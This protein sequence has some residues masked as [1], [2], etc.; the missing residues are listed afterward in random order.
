MIR[1]SVCIG[2]A[3]KWMPLLLLLTTAGVSL[4]G[5]SDT[6]SGVVNKY[7]PVL[8]LQERRTGSNVNA[9]K[10]QNPDYFEVGN[11]VML[12]APKGWD[13]DPADGDAV[14]DGSKPHPNTGVYSI[15]KVD[16]VIMADSIIVFV[17]TTPFRDSLQTGE[18]AQLIYV[19]DFRNVVVEGT[20][21]G[22]HWTQESGA[23][24]VIALYVEGRLKLQADIDATGMG[25]QGADPTGDNYT[26]GCYEDDP[27]LYGRG[28]YTAA[29]D[30]LAG[31]KGEG[32]AVTTFDML[33]GKY[34]MFN[35]GGGGN[36]RFSG[37]G[38]GS[39]Y[40]QGGRGG[41]QSAGTCLT[42]SE[43]R[44]RAGI[45]LSGTYYSNTLVS[46]RLYFGGG[47]GTGTQTP[48]EQAS[49]GGDGGGIVVIIADTI[50]STGDYTI[51]SNGES[52]E[53]TALAGG[54]GGGG[55]GA[56]VLDVN[57]YKGEVVLEARGGNGGDTDNTYYTG[58]GGGGGGGIYWLS[59][60]NDTASL[61]PLKTS[62][63]G[64]EWLNGVG[65]KGSP[66]ASAEEYFDLVPPL[67]GFLFNTLPA[68]RTVCTDETPDTLFAS[69]PKGGDGTYTYQ[70]QFRYPPATEWDSLAVDTFQYYVFKGPLTE[71]IQLRRIV[72]SDDLE[73]GRDVFITYS[74]TPKIEGNT[75][76]APDIICAG[77]TAEPLV[78]FPDSILRGADMAL[79]SA[80]TSFKWIRQ[81]NGE[82]SWSDVP[83]AFGAEHTP[84]GDIVTTLY[85]R[86]AYS[87][88]CDDTSNAVQITV[89][90]TIT[91]NTIGD[92]DTLCYGQMPPDLT[93]AT[94]ENGDGS[95]TYVWQVSED[96]SSWEDSLVTA[97]NSD[98]NLPSYEST[99][100]FRRI[101]YSGADSACIDTSAMVTITV[102]DTIT[103][104]LLIPDTNL[105]T[106]CQYDQLPDG[107][108]DARMPVGGDG[109]YQYFWQ[110][111]DQSGTWADSATYPPGTKFN[112][113]TF[114]DTTYIRRLVISG[115]DDVC[116]DYSDS[117]TVG[118][119]RVI[120]DNVL[121]A[122]PG[123]FCQGDLLPELSAD[124]AQGGNG[125]GKQW[126]FRTET[127]SWNAAP[128]GGSDW[129]YTYPDPLS[130][131]M[132][133]RRYVWSEPTDSVCFSYTDAVKIT[134]Q[135]S[136]LNNDIVLV[137]GV[138]LSADIDSVCAGSDLD[139]K[140]T[141]VDQ[142]TGGDETNYAFLW[143]ESS[144]ADFSVIDQT[145]S[146]FDYSRTNL[147]DPAY[148]RRSVA[149]GV[150][151]D[152]TYLVV[153]PIQ[154]PTGRMDY[155]DGQEDTLCS[156]SELPV[157]MQVTDLFID[158]LAAGYTVYSSYSSSEH[159]GEGN[160]IFGSDDPPILDF[161]A[162]TDSAET[163]VYRLD[164][165]I[166]DR[167]C[168]SEVVDPYTPEV[169]VYYSPEASVTASDTMV[170]GSRVTLYANNKGGVS[171]RWLASTVKN[172]L[173]GADTVTI[174]ATGLQAEANVD[175]WFNDTAV[176]VYGFKLET[177][178]SI[179]RTCADSAYVTVTHYQEPALPPYF[180]RS[181]VDDF[182]DSIAID[183]V[184]FA[185]QYQLR[186]DVPS[187]SGKGM[188]SI[189]DG[190]P[191]ELGGD[192]FNPEMTGLLGDELDAD[193]IFVWTVANGVCEE[194]SDQLVIRRKDVDVYEGISPNGDRKNDLLA[195]RGIKH[196][197][198]ISL[199]VFNS[200]GTP[201]Y[202]MTEKDEERF[203]SLIPDD[204]DSE[205]LRVLWD[206]KV[207]G[208]VV[209]D[210]TYYYTVKFTINEGTP[211][212]R[213]YTKKS[214]LIV[215]TQRTE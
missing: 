168:K 215:S 112:L 176:I 149:S 147:R 5:Q 96:M 18:M 182:G 146:A 99:R 181:A 6:I 27:E 8:E 3:V 50:E 32:A 148:F 25:F 144:Q 57:H 53:A 159:S 47:G 34:P 33:R 41:G 142:L 189:P 166:D 143:E 87:G 211:R 109:T 172:N 36:A 160:F 38:G 100:Y 184:Y 20:L 110:V 164:S 141:D 98:F 163:Y 72:S 19:P 16:S 173:D 124:E 214:Y 206:G 155:A 114:D 60:Q 120:T 154:L 26:G 167:G 30:Y 195:M 134:V 170:C 151:E 190:N 177:S 93:G 108:I 65:A 123:T 14:D 158:P 210:G 45:D 42:S 180:L 73:E 24:G 102:L 71:P 77:L 186:V 150:C 66:G 116:V 11:V 192:P 59:L 105:I 61:N 161:F 133:F 92:T 58:P 145:G 46:N 106:I 10:V 113:S 69:K 85:R 135:D 21:T 130:E 52:V 187:A 84:S 213:T 198:R 175:L 188:W 80:D 171:W 15:N 185:D 49:A 203:V 94:P 48:A 191:A 43:T 201:V 196:A 132:Y 9:L 95:Y 193:N 178:G 199:T 83:D 162:S 194:Q 212:E 63:E 74:I 126:Q 117:L 125:I 97:V 81:P 28:S 79:P 44:G 2:R 208:S 90:P 202:S 107:G 76:E 101:I 103:N 152:T 111:R 165:I 104:N 169:L 138:I 17:A 13:I 174:N 183:S 205:A 200:W 156:S 128:G 35:G 4:F 204:E 67:N 62:S 86:V 197:D 54:G 55:G 29:E 1:K 137:N 157:Q 153:H 51:R 122:T 89:L 40:T 139:L 78:Q 115:S 75:I 209:P 91:K 23:G 12:Y 31:L 39:N 37:G 136:I 68:D 121:T 22:K 118:I 179:G 82:T 127:G 119:V 64:G 56:I 70:W 88:V 131:T 207:N 129:N 140:G 7:S